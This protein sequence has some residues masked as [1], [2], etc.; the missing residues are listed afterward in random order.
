[1]GCREE[2]LGNKK[3]D[4]YEKIES[5]KRLLGK[6]EKGNKPGEERDL[7]P[8]KE[9]AGHIKVLLLTSLGKGG[10]EMKRLG[11]LRRLRRLIKRG[12]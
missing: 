9:E 4:Y 8:G 7:G 12:R 1:M 11:S 2:K 3:T 5:K 10:K 6:D